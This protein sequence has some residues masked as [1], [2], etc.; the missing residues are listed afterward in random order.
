MFKKILELAGKGSIIKSNIIVVFCAILIAG[1]VGAFIFLPHILAP[2]AL[3]LSNVV[4]VILMVIAFQ[5]ISHIM[6]SI[7][8]KKE[9]EICERK[10]AEKDLADRI[11][12]L[13]NENRELTSKLDTWGQMAAAPSS[14]TFASEL[15][16]RIYEKKSYLVK[17][18][19]LEE[20]IADPNFKPADPASFKERF[21]KWR[22]DLSHS[23]EKTVLYIGKHYESKALGID[24]SKVK[25]A[26]EGG[27]IALYGASITMLH[28]L[29]PAIDE[30][31]IE[32]CWV[33]NNDQD[34]NDKKKKII[35][36]NT[37][38]HY[39]DIPELYSKQCQSHAKEE[40]DAEVKSLCE[41]YTK[42]FRDCLSQ[43]FPG[44]V[45]VDSIE[46][47]TTTWY[48][49]NEN[50][51]DKRIAPIASGMFLVSNILKSF[52]VDPTLEI[53]DN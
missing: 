9:E 42:I 22:D 46:D 32:H 35:S 8:N 11:E 48:A 20:L 3:V 27:R 24:F 5:P 28:N 41:H 12:S 2:L 33:L 26:V 23:G 49:L 51:Q 34:K 36:I 38:D 25:Y 15:I 31:D 21:L 50:A 40:V 7:L 37:A 14:V 18:E 30:G 39:S 53:T 45:F 19:S 10:K 44:V 4:T 1:N 47:S 17:E 29:A 13:E 6:Q 43:H 16:T 52:N